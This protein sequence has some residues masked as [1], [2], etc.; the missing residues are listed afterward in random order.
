[1][2]SYEFGVSD[3]LEQELRDVHEYI[4]K[5]VHSDTRCTFADDAKRASGQIARRQQRSVSVALKRDQ[6]GTRL[7]TWKIEIDNQDYLR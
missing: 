1:M 2:K 5:M 4:D 6:E 7:E 3:C